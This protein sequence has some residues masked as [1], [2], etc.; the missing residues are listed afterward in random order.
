MEVLTSERAKP[1]LPFAGT[2]QLLDFPLSNLANSGISDVWISLQYQSSTLESSV[3][4]GRPWDLDRN[5]GGLR[6][7][8]P[9]EGSGRPEE[10]G[11]ARGNADVLYRIRRQIQEAEPEAVLVLSSDHVYRFDYTEA[12]GTHRR[13]GAECTIVTSEVAREQAGH[14]AT[15]ETTK[16]GRVNGFAYKPDKPTTTTVATEIF[17]YDPK[18]LI[19]VLEELHAERSGHVEEG[20]TGLGD[21]G[22]HLVPRFVQRKTAYV[23]PMP[24]YWRDLGQPHLYL[25]AHRDVLTDDLGLFDD[26]RWPIRTRQPQR[27]SARVLEGGVVEDSLLSPGTRVCGTVRRSVLGPGVL[28]EEGATV[29]DSVLFADVVVRAGATVDWSIVDQHTVVGAKARVGS[30]DAL[31]GSDSEHITLI[32]QDV[33]ISEGA[34]VALGARLQP[35]ETV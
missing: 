35:R 2:Y 11:F 5:Y 10:E 7:L 19:E 16:R 1:A 23:H 30:P 3:A 27:V 29:T 32:G 24:G 20:D 21:F 34:S 25:A 22:D 8:M 12:I 33:R 15:V 6:L 14:H 28:V 31:A 26:A 13:F 18:A 9:Q 17:V 4:N